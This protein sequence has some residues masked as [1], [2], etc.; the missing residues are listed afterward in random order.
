MEYDPNGRMLSVW[1]TINDNIAGKKQL[2][3]QEYN[4]LGQLLNKKLA[5]AFNSGT[6]LEQLTF[7]Y[8]IRGWMTGINKGYIEGTANRFFGMELGYDKDGYAGFSNKQYNGNISGIIWRSKGD[9]EKR[10]YDFGYD[11]ANRIL[12]ADFTQETVNVWNTSAGLDFSMKMGDGVDTSTAYDEN[13]N[14]KS[15]KH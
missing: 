12:K 15:M 11:A 5:P 13:G 10:K 9:G 2:A 6:G 8:S 14:I 3:V 1:K 7:D 4:E